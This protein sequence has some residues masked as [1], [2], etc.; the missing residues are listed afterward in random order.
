M[1]LVPFAVKLARFQAL[2]AH[3]KVPEYL[4]RRRKKRAVARK[5]RTALVVKVRAMLGYKPLKLSPE[6]RQALAEGY[7]RWRKTKRGVKRKADGV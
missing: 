3:K 1:A 7:Q 4:R 2:P 5:K 6:H